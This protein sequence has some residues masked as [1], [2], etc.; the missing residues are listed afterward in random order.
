MNFTRTRSKKLMWKSTLGM[1]IMCEIR[2]FRYH[3][4]VNIFSNVD[5]NQFHF[6]GPLPL[7]DVKWKQIGLTKNKRQTIF[8]FRLFYATELYFYFR[9]KQKNLF[10]FLTHFCS[11]DSFSYNKCCIYLTEQVYP[12]ALCIYIWKIIAKEIKQKA[13]VHGNTIYEIEFK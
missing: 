8:V 7:M 2:D 12:C 9:I 3:I 11:Q 6:L 5:P 4:V 13:K 10:L 1:V